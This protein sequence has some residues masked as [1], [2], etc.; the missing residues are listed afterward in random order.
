MV[1]I[2][3]AQNVDVQRDTGGLTETVQAVWDHLSGQIANLRILKA[4]SADEEWPRRYV[5]HGASQSLIERSMGIAES[6][7]ALSVS[8]CPREGFAD[9][10]EGVLG[11]VM[12]VNY[13]ITCGQ[14]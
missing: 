12:V 3:T 9:G 10:E 11:S 6:F 2:F 1:V 13:N 4:E 7:D 5:D 8:Q 14:P